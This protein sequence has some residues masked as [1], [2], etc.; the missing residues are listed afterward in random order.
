MSTIREHTRFYWVSPVLV[1]L[2]WCAPAIAESPRAL[3]DAG[4]R[5][6]GQAQY[7]QA[8]KAYE[9]AGNI[10]PESACVYFNKGAAYYQQ[11]EYDK[12]K[13]AFEQA[14]VKADD[15]KLE[16]RSQYNLGNCMYRQGE[17]QQQSDLQAAV[18]TFEDGVRFYQ[19]A[20]DLDPELTDAAHNLEVTRLTMKAVMDEIKRRKEEAKKQQQQQQDIQDQ[21]KKLIADQE[22]TRNQTAQ[23]AQTPPA[24]SEPPP[25]PETEG[26]DEVQESADTTQ[27]DTGVPSKPLDDLAGQ[28]QKNRE[29]AQ[30]LSQEMAAQTAS[31]TAPG[32]SEPPEPA[33]PSSPLEQARE[34]I[35]QAIGHQEDAEQ[36][37]REG[38]PQAAQTPQDQ[39]LEQLKKA[40]DAL[41]NGGQA[42]S[43]QDGQQKQ[44]TPPE[45]DEKQN[46]TESQE[47]AQ[48]KEQEQNQQNAEQAQSQQES[49]EGESNEGEMQQAMPLN[50]TARDIL[51]EEQ[52]QSRQRQAVI[53]GY[54]PVDK[55]W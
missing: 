6:Y 5:A 49:P 35:D 31:Q 51:R 19:R 12:A 29:D 22:Q 27:D 53:G 25:E 32:A 17:S 45:K 16:A 13:E 50:E 11:K 26:K 2:L 28:Q 39:A 23:A 42:G 15:V 8:L 52:E 41:N 48:P 34:H 33:S 9:E 21:L 43:Q 47:Q 24:D 46:Q 3:V 14:S 37:L 18:K 38:D 20:L 4:N 10:D 1:A 7:D 55:D 54:I 44:E 40:L 36:K 30:N